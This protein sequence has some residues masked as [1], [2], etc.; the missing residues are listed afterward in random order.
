MKGLQQHFQRRR[1]GFSVME[2]LIALVFLMV[3][4]VGM[5]SIFSSSNRGSLDAFR[6]T[7]ARTLALETLEWVSGLGYEGLVA[8]EKMTVNPISQRLCLGTFQAVDTMLLDDGSM[9]FYS[10]EY[11]QFQRRVQLVHYPNDRLYLVRVTVR[12]KQRV[13][14]RRGSIVLEKLVGAEYD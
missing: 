8:A 12:A 2:I 3:A 1:S 7:Y 6:E 4:L 5:F 10:K 14:F 11:Q 13:R 9:I